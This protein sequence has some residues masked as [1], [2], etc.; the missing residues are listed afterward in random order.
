MAN[1]A[2]PP[3]SPCGASICII[4]PSGSAASSSFMLFRFSSSGAAVSGRE[5]V[6]FIM[7]VKWVLALV[8]VAPGLSSSS[9]FSLVHF[10]A[11]VS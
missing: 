4:P 9:L 11:C 6:A 10:F 3:A 8:S 2:E 1:D 5:S 7:S